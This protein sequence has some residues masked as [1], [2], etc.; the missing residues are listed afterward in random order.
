[1]DIRNA[2]STALPDPLWGQSSGSQVWVVIADIREWGRWREQAL[3]LLDDQQRSR[4]ERMRNLEARETLVIAYALHRIFMGHY[5][6]MPPEAV[7]LWRDSLG[8]PRVGEGM[9]ATSLSH[10]G[11]LV[12]VAAGGFRPLGVDI[13][14]ASRASGMQAIAE[15]ICQPAES[16]TIQRLPVSERDTAL[17]SLWTG[18]EA[19]LKALGVGFSNGEMNQFSLP[20]DDG[21]YMGKHGDPLKITKLYQQQEWVATVA[22]APEDT[23]KSCRVTPCAASC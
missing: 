11:H 10:A 8:C 3:R 14:P 19:I 16:D 4:M 9:A 7:P 2:F 1:M 22:C 12:A 18:K 6:G 21:F 13:E 20:A 5:L 15:S 17:L 23:A